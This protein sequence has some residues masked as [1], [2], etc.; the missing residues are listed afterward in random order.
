MAL[1]FAGTGRPMSQNSFNSAVNQLNC[2]TASLWAVLSV[3]TRGFGFLADK[4]PKILFERHIFSARTGHA[5][6]ST[7][8]DISQTTRGGYAGGAAEYDRL[9]R[10]IQLNRR[11]ALE[12]ASWGMG[13]VMGFNAT[14]L[15]YPGV[16][17]MVAAFET[18]EDAQ[19]EGCVRYVLRNA[20][21]QQ[22]LQGRDWGRVAFYYNGSAYADNQYDT[23]LAGFYAHFSVAGQMPSVSVRAAQARLTYLNIDPNGV[24][25]IMGPRTRA[26]LLRFQKARGLQQTADLDA[27][28]D[29]AL[30][31]A[32]GV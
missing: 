32:V 18:G 31:A 26:A 28:T 19:L 6:D 8:P 11:A 24:D 23:K 4:R 14:G 13:Q 29:A 17:D 9:A 25:G 7:N 15:Q 22:A 16:E 10:A 20:V 1:D 3:E 30:A 5:F 27:A 12:S 2:D 21:L